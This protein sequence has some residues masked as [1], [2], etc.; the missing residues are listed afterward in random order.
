MLN[1]TEPTM[2]MKR[3]EM[4]NFSNMPCNSSLDGDEHFEES[5]AER[6]QQLQVYTSYTY[7][8]E[9]SEMAREPVFF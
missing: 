9:D 4:V 6:S 7:S 3:L 5:L 1:E 8:V 2:T